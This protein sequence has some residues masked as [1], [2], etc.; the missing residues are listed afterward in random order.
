M[1]QNQKEVEQEKSSAVKPINIK[2]VFAVKNPTLARLMPGFVY[3]FI[4]S[5]L[6]LDVINQIIKDHGHL[7]GV[8]FINKVVE[9]F[10]V[11]VN[12]YGM[13]N[14]PDSG[15]FIFASNH[16]L[17]GF[18]GMLLLK[19]VDEKLGNAKFLTNDILLNI[20][21][22]KPLFVPVN[23]HGGHSRDAAKILS[24]TYSSDAQVLIF[25]AGL[26]SR[27]IKG[28]IVDLEWKK[29]FITKSIR[30]KRDVVPVFVAGHNSRRFYN[31]ANLRK[32]LRIKWN[33]EMF[34]LPG[35]TVRH[36]NTDVHIYFGKPIP[37]TTFDSSKTHQE[38]AQWTKEE[39]YKLAPAAIS[40]NK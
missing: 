22:L 2:E 8:A 10:N 27:K 6:E 15:R 37:Y 28:K 17:G 4:H 26:A 14:I 34:L 40:A 20:P 30:Y 3:H 29:H 39:T 23:K 35:E 19:A 11:R 5:V 24:D 9:D 21:Q 25:P 36:R 38:W 33:L 1:Q 16:P 13:E 12:I 7:E 18:D 32:S 31:A